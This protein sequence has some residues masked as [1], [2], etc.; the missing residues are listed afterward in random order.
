MPI[1]VTCSNCGGVLHAP[2]DAGGKR[3]RCPTCGNIL[4][5][6]AAEVIKPAAMLGDT[7]K[8]TAGPRQQSFGEFALGSQVGPPPG[9]T[10]A[11]PVDGRKQSVTA[12]EPPRPT[13]PFARKNKPTAAPV[14]PET[15]VA[16]Q[17]SRVRGGLFWNQFAAFV[18]ALPAIG[19]GGLFTAEQ[20]AK[21]E[22]V[23]NSDIA[24]LGLGLR[25]FLPVGIVAVCLL[26]GLSTLTLGRLGLMNIPR[27]GQGSGLAFLVTLLTATAAICT[28]LFF[29]HHIILLATGGQPTFLLFPPDS[30]QGQSQ[31]FAFL[32]GSAALLAAE[33]AFAAFVGRLGACLDD[34]KSAARSTKYTL[35]CSL[36]LIGLFATTAVLPTA[37]GAGKTLEDAGKETN[38]QIVMPFYKT[39]VQPLFAQ[40]GEY[41]SLVVP[42]L[43][44]LGGLVWLVMMIRL[45]GAGRAAIAATISK[46]G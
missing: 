32:G 28:G 44:V 16:I 12:A 9:T 39:T 27:R 15:A 45:A 14:V 41:E 3:G 21:K 26:L 34:A 33:F 13:D 1:K 37:F 4:P 31:R 7:G 35:L 38:A 30:F 24:A 11:A 2:D 23:P 29:G 43:V 10:E 19:L 25:D 40:L 22:L 5:I 6:P 17:W 46:A 20:F 42:G 18:L 36:I 8:A